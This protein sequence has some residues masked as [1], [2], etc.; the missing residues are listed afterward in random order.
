MSIFDVFMKIHDAKTSKWGQHGV[1]FSENHDEKDY[2]VNHPIS[3]PWFLGAN[4]KV[5]H[6]FIQRQFWNLV[7]N[8]KHSWQKYNLSNS[9][10][11]SLPNNTVEALFVLFAT[12]LALP[13]NKQVGT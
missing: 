4:S 10:I 12:L 8:P 7:T 6:V 9:Q 3:L 2:Q 1:V 5:I 11:T 13:I